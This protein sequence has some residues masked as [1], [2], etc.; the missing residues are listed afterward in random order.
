MEVELS[1]FMPLKKDKPIDLSF[2]H[3]DWRIDRGKSA[4]EESAY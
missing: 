2:L 4:N 1:F 3:F